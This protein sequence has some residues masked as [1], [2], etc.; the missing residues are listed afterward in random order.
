M[1]G[2]KLKN[3][4]SLILIAG[5]IY[6]LLLGAR[7]FLGSVWGQ[8]EAAERWNSAP[9]PRTA[10]PDLGSAIAKLEIPRLDASWFVFEGTGHRE[11][12][13]GPGHMTGTARPGV[14]GNCVIAG[15]RDTH[16]RVLK[17]IRK[18]D[19]ILV[20][21]PGGRQ[22]HYTVMRISVVKPTN[23]QALQPTTATV[24]N[25]IT[26]YPFYYVGPAPERFVVEAQ[27]ADTRAASSVH[28]PAHSATPG[29]PS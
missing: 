25:L 16:F 5:G 4:F 11:L 9:A 22:F 21:T 24:M 10:V 3:I 14:P 20:T 18:G 27:A 29:A 28:S 15:H 17:D 13:L 12:R 23:T 2:K 26:C 1:R 19:D 6:L 8:R 7:E